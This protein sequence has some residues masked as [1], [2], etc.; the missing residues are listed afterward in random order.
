MLDPTRTA[1]RKRHKEP[2]PLSKHEDLTPFQRELEQNPYAQALAKPPRTCAV[3]T[4]RLPHFFYLDFYAISHPETS[5][6]WLMPATPSTRP[7]GSTQSP[8]GRTLA[9]RS[10]LKYLGAHLGTR[11]DNTRR[12]TIARAQER[13]RGRPQPVWR[14][15]MDAFV[16]PLL[17]KDVMQKLHWPLH[18]NTHFVSALP[19]APSPAVEDGEEQKEPQHPDGDVACIIYFLS[20]T[21]RALDSVSER[22]AAIEERTISLADALFN[23]RRKA[24]IRIFGSEGIKNEPPLLPPPS[25]LPSVLYP[26]LYFPTILHNGTRMPAYSLPDL[27]GAEQTAELLAGTTWE[28]AKGVVLRKS[29]LTTVTQMA[30]LKLQGFVAEGRAR[31]RTGAE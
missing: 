31:V 8:L 24:R 19:D 27:L 2:K 11:K 13:L 5:K 10:M 16:L 6:P 12:A 23:G 21:T 29:R 28:G 7:P 3:T 1:A 4:T 14:E 9:R 22:L 30:L 25:V 26:P 17:Q 15:D 18:R 20:F